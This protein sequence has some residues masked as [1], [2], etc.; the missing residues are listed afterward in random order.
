MYYLVVLKKKIRPLATE[1]LF[2]YKQID[3]LHSLF[4]ADE[5]NAR[6]AVSMSEE[7]AFALYASLQVSNK[8]LL[9]DDGQTVLLEFVRII[10]ENPTDKNLKNVMKQLI[11]SNNFTIKNVREKIYHL[12]GFS[13]LDVELYTLRL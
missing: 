9:T 10:M 12:P 13:E 3:E 2:K 8:F 4:R 7:L 6:V 5:S 1:H 11:D